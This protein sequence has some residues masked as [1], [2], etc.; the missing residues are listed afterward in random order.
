MDNRINIEKTFEV[1]VSVS[2]AETRATEFMSRIGYQQSN[3]S[4]LEFRRGSLIGSL[5]SLNSPRKWKSQFS[6]TAQSLETHLSE[7]SM[8]LDVNTRGQTVTKFESEYWKTEFE[9]IQ[10]AILSDYL[11]VGEFDRDYARLMKSNRKEFWKTLS[12]ELGIGIFVVVPV[13]ILIS[14]IDLSLSDIGIIV[15]IVI[16]IALIMKYRK[17]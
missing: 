16:G 3:N 14:F 4:I 15:A 12:V 17:K 10:K 5:T 6:F 11:N 2:E 13:T 7:I 1:S 9:Y 8:V